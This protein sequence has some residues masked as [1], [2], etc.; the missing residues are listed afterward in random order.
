MKNFIIKFLITFFGILTILNVEVMMNF[1]H[2]RN[3]DHIMWL[4]LFI[5]LLG[6]IILGLLKKISKLWML[7]ILLV[8]LYLVITLI[9]FA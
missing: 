3:I 5:L 9:I 2:P 1:L 7:D 4:T 8:I 6:S